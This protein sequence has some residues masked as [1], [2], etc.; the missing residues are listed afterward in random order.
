MRERR[1]RH[2]VL[3]GSG[4]RLG[5]MTLCVV[6]AW[7][8]LSTF[9]WESLASSARVLTSPVTQ[10]GRRVG[11]K[12]ALLSLVGTA[13]DSAV[14]PREKRGRGSRAHF[15]RPHP[16]GVGGQIHPPLSRRLR[17]AESIAPRSSLLGTGPR[18]LRRRDLHLMSSFLRKNQVEGLPRA[19]HES[20]GCESSDSGGARCSDDT[21]FASM[22]WAR[23]VM[24]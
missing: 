6:T 12:H 11:S 8:G 14:S 24:G 18:R 9:D 5:R 20:V 21:R 10:W 17:C 23:P 15:F 19:L 4:E 13:T 7:S 22:R 2:L 1:A 3:Q 16:F